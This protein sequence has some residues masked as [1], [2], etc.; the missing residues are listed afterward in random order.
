MPNTSFRLS[1]D[2]TRLPKI[3]I[4]D[5]AMQ[6]V[7]LTSGESLT[8]IGLDQDDVGSLLRQQAHI[9]RSALLLE[10][11]GTQSPE[12]ILGAMLDDLAELALDCWPR[13]YG[14]DEATLFKVLKHAE[15]DRLISMPWLRAAAKLIGRGHR[16]R[17]RHIA[18]EIEFAQLMRAIDPRQPVLVAAID[19]IFASK[20]APIIQVI[21]WC[22]GRGA[23]ALVTLTSRPSFVAP[24]D[25]LFY[26]A[27]EVIRE[28]KPAQERFIPAHSRAHPM[29]SIEQR[30]EAALQRDSELGPLFT[31]NQTVAI[32]GFGP[33]PKVD[34]LWSEGRVIVELDGPE[35]QDDPKFANDRHRDYEL[36]TAG[37]LVLRIT[38]R[39]VETD[40]QHAIEKIRNVVKFR[41]Q[42]K[43]QS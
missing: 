43:V 13:W 18:K 6:I 4:A 37:Y 38:N 9:S 11:K 41:R 3:E 14:I 17:L 15:Q 24:Y 1:I 33:F 10:T 12:K 21:E 29:S 25:R 19:P 8:L 28:I 22:K 2:D 5:I 26:T 30:V 39:Q 35:H 27:H 36:L 32:N 7:A 40:L 31:C 16:P 34:L 20:A 42:I 23:S